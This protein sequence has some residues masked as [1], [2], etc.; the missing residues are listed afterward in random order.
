MS[1]PFKTGIPLVSSY[2]YAHIY[3]TYHSTIVLFVDLLKHFN[4]I[5]L[6]EMLWPQVCQWLP[7]VEEFAQEIASDSNLVCQISDYVR[8]SATVI[9]AHYIIFPADFWRR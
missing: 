5:I 8:I 7:Q 2:V 4:E 6:S 9:S 3:L 1:C